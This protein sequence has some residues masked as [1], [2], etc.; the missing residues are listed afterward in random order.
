MLRTC[1]AGERAS[2]EAWSGDRQMTAEAEALRHYEN[3]EVVRRYGERST[4]YPAEEVLIEQFGEQ[5]DGKRV[6]DIGCGGG[7]TSA[8][9]AAM[10]KSYV[11]LD[12]AA[13]MV[14]ICRQR[15]PELSFVQGDATRL[16]GFDDASVDFVLFSYN[17]I[18]TMS[19]AM[20]LRVFAAVKR[21]LVANGW[22]AFSSHNRDYA[23]IVR[24][25]DPRAGLDP[26]SLKRNVKNVISYLKVLHLEEIERDYAILS[27]PIC[28]YCQLN[29]FIT[30]PA[31]VDQLRLNGFD[32]ISIISW[33]GRLVTAEEVDSAN[34]SFYYLCRSSEV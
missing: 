29:Y 17:G 32:E 7:R 23:H 14:E 15:Y 4:L 22:L 31:Q 13:P 8:K 10:A 30:K 16:D 21:V 3:A 24:W 2:V 1:S 28:G 33:D 18:D 19:H 6:L 12:Y 5:I 26:K 25:F 34:V 20:R 27:D 9:L 11:G